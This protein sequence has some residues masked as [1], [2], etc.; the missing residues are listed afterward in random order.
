MKKREESWNYRPDIDGLRA[1]AVMAVIVFHL[2]PNKLTGGFLGVDIFFL[3]S[4]FLISG[5][6]LNKL[7][8][9]SFSFLEFYSRRIKRIFPALI[10]VLFTCLLLGGL[11]LF[12]QEYQYLAKHVVT[13]STFT[14]NFAYLSE[15]GYFDTSSNLKPLL[16]TWSLSIEEQ[17]YLFW[18]FLLVFLYKKTKKPIKYMYSLIIISLALQIVLMLKNPDVA[19][20]LPFTR[21]WEFAIGGLISYS[22]VSE[23]GYLRKFFDEK[24]II[25]KSKKNQIM[26]EIL[27]VLGIIF[28]IVSL[29]IAKNKEDYIGWTILALF[30]A[31]LIIMSGPKTWTNKIILSNKAFVFTGLISYALYL[32]HWPIIFFA[33]TFN[34]E[35]NSF[36]ISFLIIILCFLMSW[37]TYRFVEKPIR[38]NKNMNVALILIICMILT[39]TI[40]VIVY[41]NSGLKNRFP[42]Q[43]KMVNQIRL[44]PPQKNWTKTTEKGIC[45][46]YQSIIEP[47]LDKLTCRTYGNGSKIIFLIGD[48][49]TASIFESY[50]TELKNTGYKLIELGLS[51]CTYIYYEKDLEELKISEARKNNIRLCKIKFDKIVEIVKSEKNTSGVIYVNFGWGEGKYNYEK[52]MNYVLDSF[53]NNTKVVWFLQTP[54]VP[55]RLTKCI[56][57]S[58]FNNQELVNCSFSKEYYENWMTG[59]EETIE[60]IIKKH[61]N[62]ITLDSSEVLCNK[63]ECYLMVNG[64]FLYRD[65]N[66]INKI[67]GKK[68]SEKFPI[69]EYFSQ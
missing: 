42:E 3:I 25:S 9:D 69:S 14:S 18:P 12:S 54:Q 40:G 64:T 68:I 41:E 13:S 20:Y 28:T 52:L 45:E 32:W 7:K 33:E 15:T 37:L 27:A 44:I 1:I 63:N 50:K 6:I 2:F 58:L 49:Q 61:Q 16:H 4:G 19:F 46:Y 60:R 23:K 17:F 38:S 66:H 57:R 53:G 34:L 43:E 29:F 22:M 65:N 67:G 55:F 59:Y 26:L 35:T 24:E 48:S 56:S 62:V 30:G 10:L 47:Q 51:G 36:E 31:S 21:F 39:A 8:S 5:I 11:F